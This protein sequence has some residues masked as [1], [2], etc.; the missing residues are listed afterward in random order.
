MDGIPFRIGRNRLIALVTAPINQLLATYNAKNTYP[1]VMK[2][3]FGK[4]LQYYRVINI[5]KLIWPMTVGQNGKKSNHSTAE[6][7]CTEYMREFSN[8]AHA[9][10]RHFE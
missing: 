7:F 1:T 10:K 8:V 9:C 2:S 6:N 5:C 3:Y 4:K